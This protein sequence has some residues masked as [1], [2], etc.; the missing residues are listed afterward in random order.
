MKSPEG[1][2]LRGA[3]IDKHWVT[4]SGYFSCV[5]ASGKWLGHAP[6]DKVLEAFRSLP[7]AERKP[8]R[9]DVPDLDAAQ[10]VIASPPAGGLVLR[11][12]G[13]FLA[14][15]DRG[16]LRHVTQADFPRSRGDLG[17]LLEPN[18]EYMWLTAHEWQ[19]LVPAKPVRG[20][21]LPVSSAISERITRFHLSPRRALTSEDGIVPKNAIKKAA[22]TLIVDEVS[23]ERIRLRL[24]GSIHWG[25][26][27]DA[28]KAT[29][30]NGPL[31]FGYAAPIHG[32]LEYDRTKNAFVRFDVVAPGDVW[33]RWGDANGNS[34]T[35]ER[36]GRTPIGFAFELVQGGSPTN[37]LPPAGH[38]GRALRAG[39][40]GTPK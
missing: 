31:P 35:V 12:Y 17:F 13:R 24:E 21:T 36:A 15:D 18:T 16:E 5:L 7:E 30:P 29:T 28:A 6:S 19:A 34:Q 9:I 14:R 22:L 32:I 25:S 1:E 26:D 11:V 20:Q 38:G 40:F 27:Y 23:E 39:Y 3:G 37:R 33:G 2:F 8:G 4:S 10:T